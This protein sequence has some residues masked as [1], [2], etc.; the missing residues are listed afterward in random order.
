M[1]PVNN[2]QI[3][4]SGRNR[5]VQQTS[6]E[7]GLAHRLGSQHVVP[8]RQPRERERSI[9]PRV[10]DVPTK[11]VSLNV[12]VPVRRHVAGIELLHGFVKVEPHAHVRKSIR[13]HNLAGDTAATLDLEP[14][15]LRRVVDIQP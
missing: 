15:V 8:E 6:S 1:V 2:T 4:R 5:V 10:D 14:Q 3:I 9:G 11:S 7:E 12:G 13:P